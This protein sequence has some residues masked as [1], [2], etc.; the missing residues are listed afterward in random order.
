MIVAADAAVEGPAIIT[1]PKS[2]K[3]VTPFDDRYRAMQAEI[4]AIE[5]TVGIETTSLIQ[6]G[7]VQNAIHTGVLM[8]DLT[9]GGGAAP[10]R[11]TILPGL[12]GSGKSTIV[13]NLAAVCA[14][15]QIPIFWFDAEGALDPNYVGRIFSRYGLRIPDLMGIRNPKTGKWDVPPLLRY[16]QDSIGEHV[17]KTIAHICHMLPFIKQN[18]ADRVW[19]RTHT[20]KGKPT[21]WVPDE[22]QGK[23]QYLFI[24]DSWPALLPEAIN[25][26]PDSSPMAANARMISAGMP[27]IKSPIAQKNCALFSVN[28]IRTR[29]GVT[30][31][32]L[33]ADVTIPFVDGRS[34]TMKEIV[35]GQIE[36]EVWSLNEETGALEPKKI[37]GWHDNGVVESPE[38]WI[39][40]RAKSVDLPNGFTS[41]TVTPD[42]EIKV[43]AGKKWKKAKNVKVGDKLLTKRVE[44]INSTLR[45]FLLGKFVGDCSLFADKRAGNA[46]FKLSN[47]EQPQYLQ[48]AL[49]KLGKFFEFKHY[50]A[51]G[52]TTD[53]EYDIYASPAMSELRTWYGKTKGRRSFIEIGPEFTALSLAVWYMDDGSLTQKGPDTFAVIISCK[54]F[55]HKPEEVA[56]VSAMLTRFGIEH[57]VAHDN[58]HVRISNAGVRT[59]CALIAPYVPACME[60]KLMPAYRGLYK[61]FELDSVPVI[62]PFEVEVTNVSV[63][64][65]RM[66]RS[67]RKFDIT[68]EDNHNYMAGSFKNGV[69]VHNSPQYEPCGL[70][71]GFFSDIRTQI[72]KV[73]P[74]TIGAGKGQFTEEPS[75]NGG[76]D[77]YVYAK[78]KNTKNK[79]FTPFREG[80]IRV[81]FEHDSAPGDGICRTWDIM[82]Y[83]LATGQAIP[84]VNQRLEM[85]LRPVSEKARAHNMFEEGKTLG[86]AEFKTI[87]EAPQYK[88]ALYQHCLQQIRSG[89]AFDIERESV[90]KA[91]EDAKS[92][93]KTSAALEGDL[94]FGAGGDEE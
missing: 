75:I 15:Q 20:V 5:K 91:I 90:F 73:A 43:G 22:R 19:Y 33:H 64:S 40:I 67:K 81:R 34:H 4:D 42:H 8:Y 47:F 27:L 58:I 55:R 24:V 36:G 78:L 60:Y 30:M 9:V 85:H 94:D 46:Q 71:L 7:Y 57:A 92:S 84:R 77:K 2:G 70:A 89:Y 39:N 63:G 72:M 38:D 35:D 18:P 83:L 69:I 79:A 37:V 23:P 59:L 51:P 31:G 17:F 14:L 62:V 3:I 11:M 49:E 66:F 29:P 16:S 80:S 50:R 53:R 65:P 56:A 10:G 25:D 76:V 93:M 6:S 52:K 87:V 12:E 13:D 86:R 74:S 82:Q 68:V 45:E 41:V 21:T 44:I 26:N 88:Q 32:C 61:D 48:W 28:Q 54:R 1:I